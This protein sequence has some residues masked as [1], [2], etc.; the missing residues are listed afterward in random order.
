M[1]ITIPNRKEWFTITMTVFGLVTW[2]IG[3]IMII[4]FG[5]MILFGTLLG[6]GGEAGMAEGFAALIFAVAVI[7]TVS[8][9]WLFGGLASIVLLLWQFTGVERIEVDAQT[10]TVRRLI[11]NLGRPKVYRAEHIKELRTVANPFSSS[12]WLWSSRMYYWGWAWGMIAFD[13]GARTI[14]F[15]GGVDEAEA[16][17]IVKAIQERFPKYRMKPEGDDVE[18]E[19]AGWHPTETMDREIY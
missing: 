6:W 7:G 18:R 11:L 12:W 13:Y 1:I 5:A 16:K 2:L 3:E 9:M 8:L 10:I 15:G 14:R 4:G 19:R 17:D